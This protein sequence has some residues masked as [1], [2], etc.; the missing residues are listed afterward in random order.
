MSSF[1]SSILLSVNYIPPDKMILERLFEHIISHEQMF[2]KMVF[3]MLYLI[4]LHIH[5]C[6]FYRL[7]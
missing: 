3:L 6:D 5:L 4:F 1:D 2:V 7:S